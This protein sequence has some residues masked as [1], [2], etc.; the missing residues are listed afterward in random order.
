[1]TRLSLLISVIFLLFKI[2]CS[3]AFAGPTFVDEFSVTDEE[4]TPTG[5]IFN[6]EGTRMYV[7]GISQDRIRQYTVGVAFDLT[8]T[9]TLERSRLIDSV[10]VSYTHLT[11]PTI[12]SV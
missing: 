9:I 4:K 12:Y 11:L 5:V 10:A 6:P 3:N 8:S 7:V 2:L 1:M